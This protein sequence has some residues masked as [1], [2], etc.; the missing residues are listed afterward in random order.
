MLTF[1]TDNSLVVYWNKSALI[2]LPVTI[3][4]EFEPV[5]GND[6]V[7]PTGKMDWSISTLLI[8]TTVK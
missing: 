7:S 1:H 5:V 3:L 2:F 8:I 6:R 4:D